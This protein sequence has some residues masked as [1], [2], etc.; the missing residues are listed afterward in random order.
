MTAVTAGATTYPVRT[1]GVIMV[2]PKWPVELTW[3][4]PDGPVSRRV[5]GAAA[6]TAEAFFAALRRPWK[7]TDTLAEFPGAR[8]PLRLGRR[9]GLARTER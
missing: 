7:P 5:E 2:V 9:A 4:T 3:M 1:N 8:P 6:P